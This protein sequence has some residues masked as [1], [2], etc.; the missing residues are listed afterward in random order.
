MF[1]LEIRSQVCL[2][3]FSRTVINK[4]M[5]MGSNSLSDNVVLQ[6]VPNR[7]QK[8]QKIWSHYWP[9]QQAAAGFSVDF[10]FCSS[11]YIPR[12]RPTRPA[13]NYLKKGTKLLYCWSFCN[14][15]TITQPQFPLGEVQKR[16]HSGRGRRP[17]SKNKS[18]QSSVIIR[19]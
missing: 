10:I 3:H 17:V 12:E 18:E 16:K 4:E 15:R 6:H 7:R 9:G 8:H 14:K 19:H 11:K 1:F 2:S 5:L 13:S